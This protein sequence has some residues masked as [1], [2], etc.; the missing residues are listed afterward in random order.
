MTQ[1]VE[2]VAEVNENTI[3]IVHAAGPILM[4]WASHPNIKGIVWAG[5]LGQE[6]GNSLADVL[7]G[8]VNPSGRLPYTLARE[9]ADYGTEV[10]Y[11]S[12]EEIVPVRRPQMLNYC[13]SLCDSAD[14]LHRRSLRR[15]QAL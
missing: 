9:R 2:A 3:V 12:D 14:R 10:I 6:L 8:K 1:M 4:P 15:L 7:F 13:Y 11:G 5:L